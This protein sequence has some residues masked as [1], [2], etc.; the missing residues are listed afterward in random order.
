MTQE[1]L[2]D[3]SKLGKRAN[4]S[5]NRIMTIKATAKTIVNIKVMNE[6]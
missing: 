1:S 2:G 5:N 4:S 6:K 3:P